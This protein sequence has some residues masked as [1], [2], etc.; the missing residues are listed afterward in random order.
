M[1]ELKLSEMGV[2]EPEYIAL[3]RSGELERRAKALETRLASLE[4]SMGSAGALQIPNTWI[5]LGGLVFLG[6]V[7]GIR[8]KVGGPR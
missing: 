5:F 3:Y 8:Q 6:L 4:D 7:V 1:T 2:R